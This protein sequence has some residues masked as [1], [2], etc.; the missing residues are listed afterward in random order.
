MWPFLKSFLQKWADASL[1][2]ENKKLQDQINKHSH[3]DAL[4]KDLELTQHGTWYSKTDNQHFCSVCMDSGKKMAVTHVGGSSTTGRC[5]NS[6][7]C[8]GFYR[9]LFP[10]YF[11]TTDP[12]E[13]GILDFDSGYDS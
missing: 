11:Q 2:N 6:K 4:T 9:N 5:V 7:L 1:L 12:E 8:G 13:R 3:I 10:Q